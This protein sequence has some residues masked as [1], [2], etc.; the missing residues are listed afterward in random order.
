MEATPWR[1]HSRVSEDADFCRRIGE[2]GADLLQQLYERSVLPSDDRQDLS[3][4]L[5]RKKASASTPEEKLTINARHLVLACCKL[6][7]GHG[8]G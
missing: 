8:L 4:P 1:E 2:A 5:Q 7:S 3:R 6:A